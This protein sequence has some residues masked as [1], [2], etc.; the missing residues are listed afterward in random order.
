MFCPSVLD[1]SINYISLD[2]T[3]T[4]LAGIFLLSGN[5]YP[6]FGVSENGKPVCLLRQNGM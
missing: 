4:H 5:M 1:I 3:W 6:I 2:Y